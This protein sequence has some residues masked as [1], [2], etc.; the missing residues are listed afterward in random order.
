MEKFL[1]DK[2]QAREK[3]IGGTNDDDDE[4]RVNTLRRTPA[5]R[6]EMKKVTSQQ[7]EHKN[8]VNSDTNNVEKSVADQDESYETHC[9]VT[10]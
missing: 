4:E 6:S 10:S 7:V 5:P 8:E 1:E 9:M 2:R 3:E